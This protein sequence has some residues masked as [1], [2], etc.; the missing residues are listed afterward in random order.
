METLSHTKW[1][2]CSES[3]KKSLL[4]FCFIWVNFSITTGILI[5]EKNSQGNNQLQGELMVMGAQKLNSAVEW[6]SLQWSPTF[7]G[8]RD[9]CSYDNLMPDGLRRSRGSDA[10]TDEPLQIQRSFAAVRPGP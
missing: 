10:S 2:L 8:T 3:H 7:L 5:A 1:L 4:P 6:F 9:W